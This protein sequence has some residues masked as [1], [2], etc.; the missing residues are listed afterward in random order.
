M[1]DV[2]CEVHTVGSRSR[3]RYSVKFWGNSHKYN[4]NRSFVIQKRAIRTIARITPWESCRGYLKKYQIRT[5]PSLYILVLLTDI[6]KRRHLFET[7]EWM[8][9]R[10]NTRR[11]DLGSVITPLLRVATHCPRHQA[12]RLLVNRLPVELKTINNVN[13]FKRKLRALFVEK[14]CYSI[15]DF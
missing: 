3:L 6:I 11:K 13:I 15:E 5:V 4:I 14:C 2:S 10:V 7:D 12:V 9:L 8:A 1:D